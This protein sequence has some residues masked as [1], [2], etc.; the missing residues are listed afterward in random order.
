MQTIEAE[1][2]NPNQALRIRAV[3][4][5][6]DSS[7]KNRVTGEEWMVESNGAYLPGVFE[8]VVSR[9][10]AFI[11]TD[12]SALHLRAKRTFTDKYVIGFLAIHAPSSAS[13]LI[14][15][16]FIHLTAP[17]Q[18]CMAAM[19]VV[20]THSHDYCV[21]LATCAN[22]LPNVPLATLC[23]STATTSEQAPQSP[24]MLALQHAMVMSGTHFSQHPLAF[25]PGNSWP[26]RPDSFAFCIYARTATR[27][28]D[29]WHTLLSTPLGILARQFMATTS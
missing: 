12:K 27:N 4:E 6:T 22:T 8:R 20:E 5:L 21:A 15:S 10:D 14:Q 28:G 2:I 24:S 16:S 19:P 1:I 7:G 23:E 3:K 17:V 9:V 18:I 29:E 13:T 11:I 25:S 26:Q